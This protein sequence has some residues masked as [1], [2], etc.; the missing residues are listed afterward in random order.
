MSSYS[1]TLEADGLHPKLHV[2]YSLADAAPSCPLYIHYS[3]PPSFILDRFQLS[4]LHQEHRFGHVAADGSQTLW[5]LGE[6]DLEAPV[7]RAGGAVVV[8][9]L[10]GG[11][12]KEREVVLP[13]H[14]RY[15][16]PVETRE[17]TSELLSVG[18][19]WPS[20]FW[21]CDT[22]DGEEALLGERTDVRIQLVIPLVHCRHSQICPTSSLPP[23]RCTVFPIPQEHP[24]P[25][26]R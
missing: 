7:Q 23:Q 26:A 5:I 2:R 18:V 25:P 24:I 19:D 16:L 14:L 3:L 11:K 9:R 22:P 6:R 15:Q 17:G 13:L 20:L 12:G 4:Q 8:A 10:E 1:A 21:L